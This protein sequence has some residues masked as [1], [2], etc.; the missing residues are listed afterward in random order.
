M[1]RP[2]PDPARQPGEFE[3]IARYFRPLAAGRE[4]ALGLADDAALIDIPAGRRLV[5]T[6]DA[7]VAGVHF[8]PEDPP[9][10]IARKMLRENLSDLAAMGAAPL[11]YVMTCCFP[12]T[13]DGAWL[14]GFAAGL[15]ADQR[16]FDI[17]L[18]GG[19]TT[20]TPG[21]LTLSL[22]AFGTVATGRELRRSTARVGDLVAVSGTI[23]D[24]A[25]GLAVIRGRIPAA[26]GTGALVDRQRLP[27]PRVALG[28]RIVG[29]ATACMDVSDGLAGDLAHICGASGLGAVVEAARVPLSPPARYILAQD[30]QWL[31]TVLTG[32]EDYELLFTLP[33]ARES[34]LAGLPVTVIGRM[35]AGSG[36]RVLDDEG[37]ALDL[38]AGGYRH[39]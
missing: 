8:F 34:E 6:A 22:T 7:L 9:D 10:L 37:N 11:S 26:E 33:P 24:A 23:G 18:M 17:A 38:G 4:G 21:P 15:A 36:V 16:E 30:P 19:D 27:Q 28:Q 20:A 3:L 12:A 5:V 35:E 32:G 13:I 29:L 25:L 1:D 39:F 2:R 14:A 31:T